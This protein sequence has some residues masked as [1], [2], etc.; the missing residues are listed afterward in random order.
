M[1]ARQARTEASMPMGISTRIWSL[2]ILP[3]F[4]RKIPGETATWSIA[5]RLCNGKYG[6]QGCAENDFLIVCLG[7][8][9]KSDGWEFDNLHPQAG[10]YKLNAKDDFDKDLVNWNGSW[11]HAPGP[12]D[13]RKM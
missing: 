12:D 9:G 6:M 3:N 13:L 8:D 10:F 11:V 2:S 5:A 4:R 1:D 7:K